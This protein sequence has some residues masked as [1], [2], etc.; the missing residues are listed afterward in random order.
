VRSYAAVLRKRNWIDGRVYWRAGIGA[1]CSVRRTSRAKLKRRDYPEEA[2]G[3]ILRGNLQRIL[4]WGC[5]NDLLIPIW[6][7]RFRFTQANNQR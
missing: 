4:R 6:E 3:K 7:Y 1:K 5:H 2:I